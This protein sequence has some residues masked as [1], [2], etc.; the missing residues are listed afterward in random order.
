MQ[1][2]FAI[3]AWLSAFDARRIDGA[4][5]GVASGWS[6]LSDALS[7]GDARIIDGAVNGLGSLVQR[8]GARIRKLQVG[9]VQVYQRLAYAG[10]FAILV[11]IALAAW[12]ANYLPMLRG[13]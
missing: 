13:A 11:V 9:R 8:S 6:R 1:P 7:V 12:L 3:S 4:V 10:L 2:F 5:N